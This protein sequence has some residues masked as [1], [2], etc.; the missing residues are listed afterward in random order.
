MAYTARSTQ[1]TGHLVTASEYNEGVNNDIY[2]KANADH[3][4]GTY[5]GDGTTSQAI[6]G[7]GFPPK[8]VRVW[9]SVTS[10]ATGTSPYATTDSFVDNNADGLAWEEDSGTSRTNRIISLDDDGF[11]VDDG[12]SDLDPNANGTTYEYLCLG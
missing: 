12:G 5:T 2:F 1:A 8:Y 6:T 11:T 10:N 4:T 9:V 7:V 3:A